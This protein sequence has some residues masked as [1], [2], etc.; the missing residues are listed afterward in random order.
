MSE[1]SAPRSGSLEELVTE[2]VD[3]FMERARRGERPRVEEYAERHPQAA[4]V[5]RG[6]LQ[7]LQVLQPSGAAGADGPGAAG[8]VT[9]RLGDFR[10]L[11]KVGHGGMGIVYEAEQISLGRR[12]ALKVLPF[13]ATMDARQLQRFQNEAKAAAGLHHTNIVPV[14]FV[15][16][17]RGVHYYAMQYI[18]G[19]DLASTIA[20]L[21]EQA[22]GKA[23]A[24]ESAKTVDAADGGPV[25]PAAS[26]A[27]DTRP[28]AAL[29]TAHS[30]RSLEH[31][32]SVA[33][34]GIQ[35]AEALDHAHQLGI[36]HRDVKPANLLVDDA[37]RLWVTDFGLAQFQ[38]DTRLTMT[39]DLVGTLRYMSPE[40]ALAKRVVVDHRTDVYSLGATLYELLTLEPVFDGKDRQAL[41]RQIAFEEPRRPRAWNRAIPAELETIVLKAMERNPLDRYHTAQELADDLRSYLEDRPIRAKRP[42]LWQRG[43]K[44]A[45]RHRAAVWASGVALVVIATALTGMVGWALHRATEA[46][47]DRQ[48]REAETAR[49]VQ[50]S[51]DESERWQ[52]QRR[53]PEALARARQAK[54]ILGGG[55][56]TEALEQRVQARLA[57]LEMLTKLENIRF[58]RR[59]PIGGPDEN[60]K[61]AEVFRAHGIDLDVLSPEEAAGRIRDRSVPLELAAALDDWYFTTL[62]QLRRD[63]KPPE[64]RL[65]L[66]AQAVDAD[67]VRSK[68]RQLFLDGVQ[69]KAISAALS[70]LLAQT[71]GEDLPPATISA[72]VHACDIYGPLEAGLRLLQQGQ[73]RYADDYWLNYDL[74]FHLML[75]RPNDHEGSRRFLAVAAA[76][77]PNDADTRWLLGVAL[78]EDKMLEEAVSTFREAIRLEPSH[79]N[80][81][82]NLAGA[83]LKKGEPK[84]LEEVIRELQ[85]IVR[86]V[87]KDAQGQYELGRLL[88][89]QKRLDEAAAAYRKAIDY[90]E[91]K[92]RA[93]DVTYLQAHLYLGEILYHQEHLDEAIAVHRE[94]IE[95][96]Q[97]PNTAL[98]VGVVFGAHVRGI[99][100]FQSRPPRLQ[101]KDR[102]RVLVAVYGALGVMLA[103][104]GDPWAGEALV[105]YERAIDLASKLDP[106]P[107][108]AVLH[109]CLAWLLATTA[110]KKL[111]DPK[112]AVASAKMAVE[113]DPKKGGYRNTLGVAHYRNGEWNEAIAALDQSIRLSD[114]GTGTGTD[115]FFLAM[116]HLQLD[117]QENARLWYD[118]GIQWMKQHEKTDAQSEGFRVEAAEALGIVAPNAKEL[119]TVQGKDKPP[120]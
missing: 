100:D 52:K 84:D 85:E 50:A 70:T 20:H 72:L 99:R 22:G 34:L 31:F 26:A 57:D 68:V 87:P 28:V 47:H 27:A 21:R 96:S 35:A 107:S 6:I 71:R 55:T 80:A 56:G 119:E 65:L 25:T 66:I 15:G 12:V 108:L 113:M 13:A 86:L 79:V 37:G 104:K 42:S 94:G 11:R 98:A 33:R 24:P 4:S 17:E 60:E 90:F 76:L 39:G 41:L 54:E 1:V 19:R 81:H 61:Y 112:R 103:K 67:P 9:G 75:L 3:E 77:R 69:A 10:L 101:D 83:L 62:G 109:N 32:R 82:R 44:W 102:D 30:A 110:D 53:I 114:G 18:E 2:V 93:I 106:P 29:S 45:R 74:S 115:F 43:R 111:R 95:K 46:L 58:R 88:H 51:L 5:L 117:D 38:S 116:A 78:Q 92:N 23:P 14:Y 63:K 16:S 59:G 91:P 118:K 97:R 8:E 64:K 73:Q 89:K 7:A 49:A 40:Q 48:M 105:C 120:K 36:V